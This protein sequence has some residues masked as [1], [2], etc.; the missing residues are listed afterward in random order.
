MQETF[1]NWMTE[2]LVW[3]QASGWVGWV[4]FI[5]IYALTCV[6]LLPG[7]ILT[8]GA[9]AAYG[10]WSG[11]L[12]VTTASV[13]GAVL[14]FA[15]SRYL[16][17]DWLHRKFS[18]N[19]KFRALDRAIAHGGWRIVLLSRLS[20][21]LPHSIVSYACGLTNIS[22]T[23]FTLASW[24]GFIPISAAYAYTGAL[25]GK[26]AKAKAGMPHGIDSWL[27]YGLGLAVTILVTIWS[28]K[29]AARALKTEVP[30]ESD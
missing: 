15:T 12:L 22:M 9:G 4:V 23:R 8:V 27:L 18:H 13:A 16:V 26:I 1:T 21:I 10:F 25:I 17:H 24:I 6:F 29:I 3:I 11:T 28:A 2:S 30:L 5:A 19:A 7:S 20:P 14:N